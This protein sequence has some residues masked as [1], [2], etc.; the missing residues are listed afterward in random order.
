MSHLMELYDKYDDAQSIADER[1]SELEANL[2]PLLE[3]S[4]VHPGNRIDSIAFYDDNAFIT[5]S[6]DACGG[7]SDTVTIPMHIIKADDPVEALRLLKAQQKLE[8][9]QKEL[10]RRQAELERM[11]ESLGMKVEKK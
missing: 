8:R 6:W 1:K 5:H 10:A 7:G 4:G 2:W 11:A 3:L 9:D